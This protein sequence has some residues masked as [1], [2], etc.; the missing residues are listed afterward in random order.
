MLVILIVGF[1]VYLARYQHLWVCALGT[2]WFRRSVYSYTVY[3]WELRL[4]TAV[5]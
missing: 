1:L 3:R 2:D 4:L 5:P